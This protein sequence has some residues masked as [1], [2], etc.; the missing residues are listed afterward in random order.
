MRKAICSTPA[1]RG[2]LDRVRGLGVKDFLPSRTGCAY[3]LQELK[4]GL[5]IQRVLRHVLIKP[6]AR[7]EGHQTATLAL[8]SPHHILPPQQRK[9][10]KLRPLLQN[11]PRPQPSLPRPPQPSHCSRQAGTGRDTYLSSRQPSCR[12][13]PSLTLL[14]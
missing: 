7:K 14:A 1:P 6:P 12:A 2:W 4:V 8:A 11:P 9:S 5:L 10:W 13:M 3:S